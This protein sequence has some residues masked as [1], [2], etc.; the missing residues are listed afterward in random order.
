[1]NSQQKIINLLTI[2]RRAGK[3]VTGFDAVSDA[4]K[5]K[6]AFCVMTASDI[7]N[8]TLKEISFI[9]KKYNV[10]IISAGLEKEELRNYLGKNTAVIAV[11]EKG[12]A[13]RFSELCENI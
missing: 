4:V 9:C 1:M 3:T 2:C 6:K 8:N 13:T 7:S 11:C 10:Q 5:N 12:F